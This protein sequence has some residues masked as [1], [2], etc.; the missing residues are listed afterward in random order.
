MYTRGVSTC[1]TGFSGTLGCLE[2]HWCCGVQTYHVSFFTNF[3]RNPY[4]YRPQ[5]KNVFT[6]LCLF[7]GL[8]GYLW[9][10]GL[11]GEGRD[12]SGT[13]SLLGGGY[14]QGMGMFGG[15]VYV[16]GVCLGGYVQDGY[17]TWDLG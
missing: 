9:L 15:S 5:T 11:S 2:M 17:R 14:V 1:D 3:D 10:H 8:V 13:R 6:G 7:R 12:I 4:F 16:Q